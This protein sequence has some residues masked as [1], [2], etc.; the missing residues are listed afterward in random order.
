MSL[1]HS[2]FDAT[3]SAA[4]ESYYPD[5]Y[6]TSGFPKLINLWWSVSNSKQRYN[7]NFRI[8]DAAVITNNKVITNLCSCE[9]LSIGW[10]GGKLYKVRIHESLL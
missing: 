10:K 8:G 9:H 5:R 1:A 6:D 2:I 3:I 7:T 4:I